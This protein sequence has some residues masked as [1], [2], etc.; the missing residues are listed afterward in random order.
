MARFVHVPRPP[1]AA[2]AGPAQG[3]D[4]RNRRAEVPSRAAG[5][6]CGHSLTALRIDPPGREPSPAGA[7]CRR[8]V[9]QGV[10][11]H[12]VSGPIAHVGQL[13]RHGVKDASYFTR[14]VPG[15]KE[16]LKGVPR[17]R[18]EEVKRQTQEADWRSLQELIADPDHGET[19]SAY[20]KDEIRQAVRRYQQF[21]T[22]QAA[23]AELAAR[24]M[25]VAP[26]VGPPP[27]EEDPAEL[28]PSAKA[29]YR[30]IAGTGRAFPRESVLEV[31]KKASLPGNLGFEHELA[32]GS[33]Y[34]ENE[35]RARVQFGALSNEA[36][37]TYL[38][39]DVAPHE[40]PPQGLVGGDLS[41]WRPT[42]GVSPSG[43]PQF[44]AEFIQAKACHQATL[45]TNVDAAVNQLEG[46]CA[47]GERE[48][49]ASDRE[50]TLRGEGFT[51]TVHVYVTDG[52]TDLGLLERTAD[53]ALQSK[54]VHRVVFQ[55]RDGRYVYPPPQSAAARGGGA[56]ALP[57]GE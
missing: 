54:Y 38:G 19:I 31:A 41:V 52:V 5:P 1:Q 42:G 22:L 50:V 44:A 34:L 47:R 11:S 36:I 2:A 24:A 57:E 3:R 8:H 37:G 27:P 23:Q 9:I 15:W 25:A 29:W 6:G 49:R 53:K 43:S 35:P 12:K 20:T 30:S 14:S 4:A 17:A 33:E 21:R 40:R 18:H 45:G 55:D 26:G 48:Q 56:G 46:R 13:A 39:G 28:S 7:A 51:G 16:L 10:L 32:I